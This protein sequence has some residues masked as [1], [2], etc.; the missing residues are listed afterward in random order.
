MTY[1]LSTLTV[2]YLKILMDKKLPL[3][4][5]LKLKNPDLMFDMVITNAY[6]C[7][8]FD[9]NMPVDES[10]EVFEKMKKLLKKEY[11]LSKCPKCG[12]IYGTFE[13]HATDEGCEKCSPM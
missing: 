5:I 1:L 12:E 3:Y 9:K 8:Q 4:Q 2:N 13:N 11:E 7:G 6:F 10:R